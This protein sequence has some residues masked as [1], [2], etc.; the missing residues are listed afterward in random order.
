MRADPDSRQ[1]LTDR[2]ER[3]PAAGLGRGFGCWSADPYF[4]SHTFTDKRLVFFFLAA[5][6]AFAGPGGVQAAAGLCPDQ[7]AAHGRVASINERLELTLEDGIQLKI[8]GIDA[9]RPTPGDPELDVR[10]RDRLAQWL[11]GQ[12]IVF[13]LLDP[14]FD[15]WGRRIA[16]VFAPVA[17]QAQAPEKP[18]PPVGE[19]ILDAGLA[20][21]EP[22][23]TARP[24]RASLIAA[25]AGAR[26]ARLG[27][28]ADPYYAVI[29][30]T[31][32]PSFAEKTGTAVLVEGRI[33]GIANR[34]PRI[35]LYFGPRQGWD[36]SVAIFPRNGKAFEAAY[37]AVADLNGRM[38]RV[39]GLLDTRFGPQIEI[40]NP[41]EIEVT[42]Q[43]QDAQVA[44]PGIP[45][46]R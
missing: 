42:G 25:E 16:F 39:R 23:A 28:W 6:L 4:R 14:G 30:A 5:L 27:L 10:A 13:H 36:F 37:A 26:T 40:S 17:G 12:E 11:I 31:D 24:C 1:R 35:M 15:R 41:D 45:A 19:A 22:S 46:P 20:R 21:Y 7:G 32:R 18:P 3:T 44:P 33:T 38:V 29:A 43:E 9:P 2:T 34:R 8:A